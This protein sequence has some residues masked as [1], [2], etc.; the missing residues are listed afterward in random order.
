MD[1]LLPSSLLP[2]LKRSK[3]FMIEMQAGGYPVQYTFLTSGLDI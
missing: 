3:Q 1:A 2:S